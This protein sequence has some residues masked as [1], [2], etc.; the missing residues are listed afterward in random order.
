MRSLDDLAFLYGTDKGTRP[1]ASGWKPKGYTKIYEEIFGHLVTEKIALL[2]IGVY[3]GASLRMWQDWMPN[4]SIY[5]LDH[6][7][8]QGL[9]SGI[10]IFT[11]DQGDPRFLALVRLEGPP[12]NIIIDDG[13]HK[14]SDHIAS[15]HGLIDRLLP[16]GFYVVEDL[17]AAPDSVP[18]L[19]DQ[20]FEFPSPSLAVLRK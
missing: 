11:G 3:K 8:P 10:V 7:P 16:G 19:K 13:S 2:E 15:F 14:T 1:V 4:A 20:G 9:P 12:F 17:H 18:W 5:G 6:H